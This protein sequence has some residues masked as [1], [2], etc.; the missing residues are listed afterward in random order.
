MAGFV[1][2][3]VRAHRLL[4]SAAL[5]TVLLATS[6]LA[7]LSA[8][9]A[10]I[11]DTGLRRS[12][13][14]QSAPRTVIDAQA[15]VTS[16]DAA[17]IDRSVRRE[18]RRAFD[19]LPTSIEAS[20][21]SGP[22]ALPRALRPED[23]G[24]GEDPDLTLFA[25]LDRDRVRMTDGRWP[26]AAPAPAKS[27]SG[28]GSGSGGRDGRATVPVAVPQTA[29]KRLGL[30]PGD[31]IDLTSRLS[32]APSVRAEVTGVY[33]AKDRDDPYWR[34]D[35]L[36]G[37]GVRT[38]AFTT[39]GPLAVDPGA[40][41]GA[42][43]PA[44][45]H[46]QGTAD[47]SG[48]SAARLGE[49][50][51]HVRASVAGFGK[52]AEV[53][54][55]TAASDLPALLDGLE[56]T[57]L[58]GRSTLLIA[59]LQ[60]AVLAGLALLLVAQLL[61]SER[62]EETALLRARGG[63]RRRIAALSG[64]EA[65]L[66]ALPGAVL[67]P[68]LAVPVVEALMGTGALGRSGVDPTVRLPAEAW[69]VAIGTALAC[70]VTVIAPTLRGQSD[71]SPLA[72]STRRRKAAALLRGGSDLALVAIAGVAYWQLE[73]RA[74][75]TGVLTGTDGDDSGALGIDPVLVTA[76]ALTLL[77][78]TVLALRLLPLA[79]RLGEHRAARSRGLAGALAGWQLSRRPMR[80]AGPALLLVL[81]VAMGVFAVGQGASWDRSQ[82]DQADF[83]TAAD[84]H[85]TGSSAPA[86][87][88][89]G[90]YDG[91]EGVRSVAP[92]ARDEFSVGE[93]R[94][95]QVLAT[96]TRQAADG[97]LRIR[98]DLTDTPLPELLRPLAGPKER[99]ASGVSL[100]ENT[101]QL[102]LGLRL[103]R[104]GKGDGADANDTVE[105]ESAVALTVEDRFGVP[106]EFLVGD[107]PADGRTHQLTARFDT[108]AGGSG[109]APAAPLRLTRLTFSHN[110]PVSDEERRLTLTGLES[111]GAEGTAEKVE[112]PDGTRWASE[113]GTEDQQQVLGTG[114]HAM[115]KVR[116]TEPGGD[117]GRP[118]SV[119]YRTGSAPAPEPYG[120]EPV[121]VDL[122]LVPGPPGGGTAGGNGSGKG[123]GKSGGE[124][125]ELPA[126]A[127]DAFLTASGAKVGDAVKAQIS[128]TELTVRLTGSIRALPGTSAVSGSKDGG[129][130]LLDLA[131]LDGAL[132]AASAKP[133]E[134]ESWW[135]DTRE[136]ETGRAVEQL[137]A[138]PALDSVVVRDELAAEL[139]GDPLSAG[140]R[141]ALTAI[142][143][144]A[145]ALAAM[146]FAVSAAG[147]VRERRAEFAVLRALGAP[148]RRLAQVLATEQSLLV[149][150]S[151]AIG[152][153]LGVLL[154]R[155]V[156]PLIVLTGEAS[157]PVPELLVRLPL[158]TLTLLLGAV[159]VVPVLVIVGTALRG[160][161][162][163]AA[164]RTERGD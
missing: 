43:E 149:L 118:L 92:L 136:G 55:A 151:L 139:R 78:G 47:F 124:A 109:G 145:A 160:A 31:R 129:A 154:T 127:T 152:L 147:A 40:F 38:L 95:A 102:R 144:A 87:G 115:P 17:A 51:D 10:T 162:P 27:G 157:Q 20:T 65:L 155:L 117:D 21:R 71:K 96:D 19:G 2:S 135:V 67:A 41:G 123:S 12:L 108:A 75:G 42:L 18:T 161:D 39:Y 70:A 122:R 3:R 24:D 112:V 62:A 100:P 32:S 77:A 50:R 119:R 37:D 104:P 29:A 153:A 99:A 83:R 13:E 110:A 103:E 128:S 76:P 59:A 89:G 88:Q 30:E 8:F 134:P 44:S 156:V 84:V 130:L 36:E 105:A 138:Q 85:V 63:S 57:M 26:A 60:L 72:R 131:E 163:V 11:G 150:L 81:A 53:G 54:G 73:R 107:L 14:H 116:A 25:S 68:L 120:I 146:G 5:L 58:V 48:L 66:L 158:G 90:V 101:R 93:E 7:V 142:A 28:S 79:A 49:L 46:W 80:G 164:L 52:S 86:F 94:T 23:A 34:L 106:Y 74:A 4:I 113:V 125:G 91:I 9:A 35:P 16:Q 69:W 22:Y 33:A 114:R 137:R 133:L 61:A 111:S 97:L 140:P 141:T 1:L 148:R 64:V 121:S 15:D 98:E 132:L 56:R 159:L 6:V 126:V 45:T 82:G 143:V